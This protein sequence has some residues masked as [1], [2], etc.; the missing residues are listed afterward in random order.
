LLLTGYQICVLL[1][2][3]LAQIL[4]VLVNIDGLSV[5]VADDALNRS[6]RLT[7]LRALGSHLSL[8]LLVGVGNILE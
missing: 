6:E 1:E 8:V 4:Q 5:E 3:M 2:R 7:E